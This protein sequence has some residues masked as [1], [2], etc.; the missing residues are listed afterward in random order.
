M[1]ASRIPIFST[2]SR[3]ELVEII[4]TTG[5]EKFSKGDTI[6]FEGMEAHTLYIIILDKDKLKSY[7]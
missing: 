5:S 4:S 2:L 1:C 3:E 7:T 6:C